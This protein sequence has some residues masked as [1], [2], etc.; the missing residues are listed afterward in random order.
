MAAAKPTTCAQ[1]RHEDKTCPISGV[2]IEDTDNPILQL[3]EQV[4]TDLLVAGTLRPSPEP[5]PPTIDR[6]ARGWVASRSTQSRGTVREV[7]KDMGDGD[8]EDLRFLFVYFDQ[9]CL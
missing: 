6:W 9:H 5:Q 4:N 1:Q 8:T 7:T 3:T 2:V